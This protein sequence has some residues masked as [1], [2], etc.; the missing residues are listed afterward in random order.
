MMAHRKAGAKAR[1]IKR[2]S[3]YGLA[4]CEMHVVTERL[5]L[6]KASEVRRLES[7]LGTPLPDGH[8]DFLT[9]YGD[10]TFCDFILV[11][12]PAR[13]LKDHDIAKERGWFNT[14]NET[15]ENFDKLFPNG[16]PRRIISIATSL[17]GDNVVFFAGS[18]EPLWIFPRHD[19]VIYKTGRTIWEAL[20][21][22]AKSGIWYEKSRFPVFNSELGQ[23]KNQ[24]VCSSPG[25]GWMHLREAITKIVWPGSILDDDKLFG[26]VTQFH[27]TRR[28]EQALI[29]AW[30]SPRKGDFDITLLSDKKSALPRRVASGLKAI[31][32]K[33]FKV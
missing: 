15:W 11:K 25:H 10:G 26:D 32:W 22:I 16:D 2:P 19:S 17:D 4:P 7:K 12:S 21:W 5:A 30:P 9:H 20:G 29:S 3:F 6:A 23:N 24:W 27:M 33:L 18:T 8:R 1:G 31:G 14:A 13:I 28:K